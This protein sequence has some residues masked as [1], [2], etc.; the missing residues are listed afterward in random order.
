LLKNRAEKKMKKLLFATL[1]LLIPAG[2]FAQANKVNVCHAT[3]KGGFQL[4]SVASSAL[5]AHLQ[6]GDKLP[7]ET[8]SQGTPY[9]GLYG[10]TVTPVTILGEDCSQSSLLKIETSQSFSGGGWA[11]WSCVEPGFPK[12]AGGGVVPDTAGVTAQGPAKPGVTVGGFTYPVYPHYTYTAPE[13]GWVVQAG[14]PLPT[15]LYVLCGK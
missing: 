1:A 10:S 13:E 12:V 9:S 3:G 4:I 14:T 11:G 2:A 7:G 8:V 5:R 15:G 6:H